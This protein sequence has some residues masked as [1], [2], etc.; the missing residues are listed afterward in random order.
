MGVPSKDRAHFLRQVDKLYDIGLIERG[1]RPDAYRAA[2][3]DAIDAFLQG[4]ADLQAVLDRVRAER[5][6]A[7]ARSRRKRTVKRRTKAIEEEGAG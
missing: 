5:S 2:D 1:D 3:A 4:A 7:E 6:T